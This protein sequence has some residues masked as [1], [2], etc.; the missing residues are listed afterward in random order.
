MK[1][2]NSD[3]TDLFRIRLTHT[4]MEPRP[5]FWNAL[6]AD[7]PQTGILNT[8][9]RPYWWRIT[10][11]V[12]AV[13]MMGGTLLTFLCLSSKPEV[14]QA[15]TQLAAQTPSFQQSAVPVAAEKA[16]QPAIQSEASAEM[17]AS[18]VA[19]RQ[20]PARIASNTSSRGNASRRG[21]ASVSDVIP[22]SHT[23]SAYPSDNH[24][25]NGETVT[26]SVSV[27]ITQRVT[28]G[29]QPVSTAA[30]KNESVETVTTHDYSAPAPH[31]WALKVGVGTSLLD[32]KV[33]KYG[34]S[35][36]YNIPLTA[37]V[38]VERRLN[39]IFSL[40][41]GVQYSYSQSDL[42]RVS[43]S[44]YPLYDNNGQQYSNEVRTSSSDYSS[45]RHVLSVPLKV[46]AVLASGQKTDL[47]ATAG[48]SVDL[49]LSDNASAQ[50]SVAAGLG[51]RYRMDD[52]WGL[53]A[54]ATVSHQFPNDRVVNL[55]TM[56]PTNLNLLC[57]IRMTY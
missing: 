7:L 33:D 19:V 53:F 2:E 46:N 16:I 56:R 24:T 57:G 44:A 26:V 37:S 34:M 17:G 55:Q 9:S 15:A 47:Y 14:Q 50:Y 43:K 28:G 6:Q 45:D 13:L 27:T 51:V 1:K 23:S 22:A 10:A 36:K 49:Y 40:E 38:S 41:A 35:G 18:P 3:I 30:D 20:Q 4:E 54:E 11:A 8:S 48:G 12:A 25:D 31:N 42:V 32:N 52:R 39:K 5:D 29:G 21:N